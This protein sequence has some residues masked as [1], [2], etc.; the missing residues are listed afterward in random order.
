MNVKR[1]ENFII[2]NFFIDM[3][4]LFSFQYA[5]PSK[6]IAGKAN[7]KANEEIKN[8]LKEKITT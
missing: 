3:G 8:K 4:E 5:S 7:L 6:L 1:I 2:T